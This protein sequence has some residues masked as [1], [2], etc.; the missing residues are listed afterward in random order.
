MAACGLR[1]ASENAEAC[2]AVFVYVKEMKDM[3][4]TNECK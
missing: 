1:A 4:V 2:L 3:K